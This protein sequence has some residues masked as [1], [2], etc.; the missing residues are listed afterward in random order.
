LKTQPKAQRFPNKPSKSNTNN[1]TMNPLLESNP[2]NSLKSEY[3]QLALQ[4][5][6][7]TVK[8]TTK[9]A[10]WRN[11][12]HFHHELKRLNLTPPSLRLHT[13]VSG[14]LAQHVI[15]SAQTK[16][17]SIRITQCHARLRHLTEDYERALS[18]LTT[19]VSSTTLTTLRDHL[20]A[21]S[22]K[23][24]NTIRERHKNKIRILSNKSTK[25]TERSRPPTH[26]NTPS[27]PLDIKSRW[28]YNNSSTTLTQA[29]TD[30]L[31]KGLAFRPTPTTPPIVDFITATETA[32]HSIGNDTAQAA[33]LRATVAYCLTHPKKATPNITT[34]ELNAIRELAHNPSITIFPAD[35]GRATVVMDTTA[36]HEKM[37]THTS[38]NPSNIKLPTD[39]TKEYKA[40]ILKIL[41]SIKPHIPPSTYHEL[42]PTTEV[43]PR[44]QG[45]PKV[46]KKDYPFRPIVSS[47]DSITA[48]ISK[49]ITRILTPLT[50]NSTY[51]VK[52]SI[53]LKN[54]LLKHT[55]PDTHILVSFD[56]TN[57]YPSIPRTPAIQAIRELLTADPTLHQRTPLTVDHIITLLEAILDLAHFRWLGDFYA[58]ISGCAM[59]DGTSSPMS[60]AFMTKYEKNALTTYRNLHDDPTAVSTISIIQFWFRQADDTLTSIHRDH[61]DRF[62]DY[63]NTIHPSIKWTSEREVNGKISMLDL[64]I[65]RQPDGTFHFDVYRKPTHT[66]QYI[67][68]DSDQPIQHKAA[69]IH[70]LTRRAHLIPTGPTRQAT[71][72]Q[73]TKEVLAVNRYPHWAFRQYQY[74]PPPPTTPTTLA[75]TT[76]PGPATITPPTT[77]TQK[78]KT[79]LFLPYF[80][81]IS[82][83]ITR[84]MRKADVG[85]IPMNKNSLRHQLVHLKDKLPKED[86]SGVIYYAP[87]A[88]TTNVSC[89]ARYIG[90]TERA[91]SVRFK[92]HHN[93]QKL[94]NS[95]EYQ[96]AIGQHQRD[97]NHYFRQSDITYLDTEANKFSRGIKEAIYARALD[98]TLNRG[99]GLRHD[100]PHDYDRI[101]QSTIHHPKPPPPCGPNSPDPA[102]HINC[103]RLKGRPVGSRSRILCLPIV[104]AAKN[105][106]LQPDADA[107]TPKR[108]PGR[109]RVNSQRAPE[110]APEPDATTASPKRRPGRP[111]ATDSTHTIQC[112]RPPIPE[113]SMTTR[114][115]TARNNSK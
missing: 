62:F 42:Y 41:E 15:T 93:R 103:T 83:P 6:R 73:R 94:P 81:G 60:N 33:E 74:H 112:P 11:H 101:I 18:T 88:G 31:T 115:R 91:M 54:E 8:L 67:P 19:L 14:H 4:S 38:G 50:I 13:N 68:W 28:L 40:H 100:L 96:S 24:F 48:P 79:T 104:S 25:A 32:A 37:V 10:N 102:T 75:N 9:L 22:T 20:R 2:F 98:P 70:S 3:G 47:R 80:R 1:P 59:G 29:Q 61:A 12:L 76:Q 69:T 35:K 72:L 44:M 45:Q 85:T 17:I 64:T 109:P 111:R 66:D 55:I 77:A 21:T 99:G 5:F 65:L 43:P 52:D 56:I 106:T 63:I 26:V 114:S 53:H 87:C 51:Q 7:K 110:P 71:E 84:A 30:I 113:L 36:Y 108:R 39:P 16:L 107:T 27:G 34:H 95:D 82:E 23:T 78:P 46:H 92:E 57:M 49:Y 58:Q 86:K 97:T 89:D 90:E 105:P